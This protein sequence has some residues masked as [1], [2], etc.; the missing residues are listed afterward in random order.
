MT[1]N[2][3]IDMAL[4]GAEHIKVI[5]NEAGEAFI[6]VQDMITCMDL[7]MVAG[8]S[9]L[10]MGKPGN[11]KSSLMRFYA[12]AME[13]A[14]FYQLLNPTTKK[15]ALF[16]PIDL[17][18]L[19]STWVRNWAGVATHPLIFVD[20]IGKAS[21]T[22]Q[23]ML[24]N[25]MEER[26]ASEGDEEIDIPMHTL[27]SATNEDFSATNPA[28]YDRFT[29]RALVKNVTGAND[30]VKLL[31]SQK[32]IATPPSVPI[33]D[34]MLIAMRQTCQTMA[35]EVSEDVIGVAVRIFS[36]LPNVQTGVTITNRRWSRLIKVAAAKALLSGRHAIEPSDLSV[37]QFMLWEKLADREDV[38]ESVI[39]VCDQDALEYK[40]KEQLF[41]EL[42][43]PFDAAMSF[44][45][46]APVMTRYKMLL[47]SIERYSGG[48]WDTMKTHIE[49]R[50]ATL[51][52]RLQTD[53]GGS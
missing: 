18:S 40:A 17:N 13:Q 9:F 46:I 38:A 34:A 36:T 21:E 39:K 19:K 24:L 44:D 5:G 27:F 1:K 14:M 3:T 11:G 33:E 42:N 29:L 31:K 20:E 8:E 10:A 47:H 32:K 25:A 7:N 28:I 51:D 35:Y 15:E 30:L 6:G 43:D 22:V 23:S 16:G 45:T 48:K 4:Q 52:E 12:G 37:G 50:M 2:K 41:D 53:I 26:K 49:T